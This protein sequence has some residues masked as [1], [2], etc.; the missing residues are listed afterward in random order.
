MPSLKI[1]ERGNH[2][3]LD[4]SSKQ[5]F[6]NPGQVEAALKRIT[7]KLKL[8]VVSEP[9]IIETQEP[10]ENITGTILLKQSSITMHVY[11]K[12]KWVCLDIYSNEEFDANKTAK[13]LIKDL[14]IIK[15][16]KQ[17]LKRGFYSGL[18]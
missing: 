12:K 3:V 13:F 11:P 16:K 18:N 8:D 4:G 7:R 17:I 14:K 15:F 6:K 2:L 9:V 5:S 10:E 1:S